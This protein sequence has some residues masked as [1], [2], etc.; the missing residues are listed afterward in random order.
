MPE[1]DYEEVVL[2]E[3]IQNNASVCDRLVSSLFFDFNSKN[4][5]IGMKTVEESFLAKNSSYLCSNI[6]Q[7]LHTLPET[8][9]IMMTEFK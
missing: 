8:N 3:T 6:G 1:E 2:D 9:H 7:D 4:H 5:K